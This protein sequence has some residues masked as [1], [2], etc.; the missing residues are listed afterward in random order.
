MKKLSLLM[1]I[2]LA[3]GFV[4]AQN[5]ADAIQIGNDQTSEI[6]Q[7][8]YHQVALTAQQG[9][10]NEILV[11]QISGS[12]QYAWVFQSGE[13]ADDAAPEDNHATVDQKYSGTGNLSFLYQYGSHNKSWQ[14]QNGSNNKF[15][16]AGNFPGDPDNIQTLPNNALPNQDGDYHENTQT[17]NG[18]SNQ[19]WIYQAGRIHVSSQVLNG[20]LNEV[21]TSQSGNTN[22]ATMAIQG[23]GNGSIYMAHEEGKFPEPEGETDEGSP[24]TG[25]N[26]N[27]GG[28]HGQG[29]GG[30]PEVIP[31]PHDET[32][33]FVSTV[34][35]SIKQMGK[36]ST[37]EMDIEG[38]Y[39]K[40]TITQRG[41]A[42]GGDTE[43]AGHYAN[44]DIT[45]DY[46]RV[47]ANQTGT[48]NNIDQDVNGANNL[49]TFMQKGNGGISV[50]DLDGVSNEIGVDQK[51]KSNYS[52]IDVEG[53]LNGNLVAGDE[54]GIKLA[55][56]GKENHSEI[57]ITGNY[58]MINAHQ[59]GGGISYITQAG[60]YNST[61]VNQFEVEN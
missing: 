39:N 52:R 47:F 51:G 27:Q 30:M 60:D 24:D 3:T 58:N 41:G 2:M 9:I 34:G 12:S 6:L 45:G 20:N 18:N 48:G 54:Y 53:N 8:G 11:E 40:A 50:I 23:V 43:Q 49:V 13:I 38:N 32:H 46:N 56:E 44:Q 37:A 28:S 14:T 21:W 10:T 16:I 35:V 36:N 22:R 25:G 15:N 4:I 55:Q 57:D 29:D 61:T 19:A 1:V 26:G 59:S 17:A 5:S 42:G 33:V 31:P 7:T